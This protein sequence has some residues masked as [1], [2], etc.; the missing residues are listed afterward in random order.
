MDR[1][2]HSKHHLFFQTVLHMYSE[3]WIA[4]LLQEKLQQLKFLSTTIK[5]HFLMLKD[6]R[7]PI[8]CQV[9]LRIVSSPPNILNDLWT[10]EPFDLGA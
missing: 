9:R 8:S 10:S 7:V 3:I 5:K 1:P 4:S 6:N 2:N